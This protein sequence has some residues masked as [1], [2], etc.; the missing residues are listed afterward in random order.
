[1]T[2]E[3]LLAEF[4]TSVLIGYLYDRRRENRHW[5]RLYQATRP[6]PMSTTPPTLTELRTPTWTEDSR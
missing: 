3:F 5:R 4:T 2:W 1:M 6:G